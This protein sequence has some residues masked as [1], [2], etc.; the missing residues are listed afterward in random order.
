MPTAHPLS[1][2]PPFSHEEATSKDMSFHSYGPTA[3]TP[4]CHEETSRYVMPNT[5]THFT[6]LIDHLFILYRFT[7]LTFRFSWVAL[8]S[9]KAE[10]H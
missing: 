3:N 4:T 6:W 7:K 1:P 10:Q 2:D 5:F 9:L 8:H